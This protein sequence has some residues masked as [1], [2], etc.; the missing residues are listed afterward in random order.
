MA[1]KA[2][3]LIDRLHDVAKSNDTLMLHYDPFPT[4]IAYAD[5]IMTREPESSPSRPIKDDFSQTVAHPVPIS[6][7]CW[8]F[9]ANTYGSV[10]MWWRRGDIVFHARHT[11]GRGAC[12]KPAA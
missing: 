8:G 11:G 7:R 6:I 3:P 2:I 5:V 1:P 10:L 12:L 4:S 9:W